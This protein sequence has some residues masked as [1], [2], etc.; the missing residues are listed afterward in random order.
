MDSP[1]FHDTTH[2]SPPSV[3]QCHPLANANETHLIIDR[4]SA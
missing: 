4:R 2:I 3:Q 1:L